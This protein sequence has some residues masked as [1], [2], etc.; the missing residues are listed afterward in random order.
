MFLFSSLQL[1]LDDGYGIKYNND[2]ED[3]EGGPFGVK[4]KKRAVCVPPTLMNIIILILCPPLAIFLDKGLKGFF[5]TI[6]CS[7]M[8]YFLY[9]FP[10]LIFAALHVLC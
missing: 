4:N 9:Y 2:K 8:T 10:G 1:I 7:L 3:A 5:P 6:I